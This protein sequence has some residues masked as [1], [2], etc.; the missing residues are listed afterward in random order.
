MY[1]MMICDSVSIFQQNLWSNMFMKWATNSN[2]R[3]FVHNKM[4]TMKG[5]N[6][7]LKEEAYALQR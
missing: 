3:A 4:N 2:S 5:K 6:E 1:H 7:Q